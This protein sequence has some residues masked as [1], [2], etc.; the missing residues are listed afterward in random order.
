MRKHLI[1]LLSI[2]IGFFLPSVAT[3]STSFKLDNDLEVLL[4]P[5]ENAI[6]IAVV[7]LYKIGDENDP[8]E[9]S[10]LCHLIEHLYYTSATDVHGA[11]PFQTVKGRYRKSVKTQSGRDYSAFTVTALPRYLEKEI[12]AAAHRMGTLKITAAD[13]AREIP[14]MS[15]SLQSMH[16]A[17]TRASAMQISGIAA[18]PLTENARRGGRLENVS[19]LSAKKINRWFRNYY[20]TKNATLVVCGQI[21]IEQTKEWIEAAFGEIVSGKSPKRK[22][23]TADPTIG[24]IS[25]AHLPS[26]PKT[27]DFGSAVLAFSGPA[28]TDEL[29][30]AFLMITAELV[31]RNHEFAGKTRR[32]RK[33][34]FA[35]DLLKDPQVCWY[36]DYL[37]YEED[38]GEAVGEIRESVAKAIKKR[39]TPK[40]NKTVFDLYGLD[41]GIA[42]P[43]PIEW[44]G[45]SHG[46]AFSAA[47]RKQLGLDPATLYAALEDVTKK[48]IQRCADQFFGEKTGAAAVVQPPRRR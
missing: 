40:S 7:T 11:R 17:S 38:H 44:T 25:S 33:P 13:V 48:D 15:E 42:E 3:A 2:S 46:I 32:G 45:Y 8:A 34:P 26:P 12:N 35:Y 30:P 41:L 31:Q 36:G 6:D 29:Y 37:E 18:L 4:S 21:D 20:K 27:H 10:G 22:P 28:P 19:S 5:T 9:Q 16:T 43:L 47:R 14:R 39:V 1:V 24:K 23:K